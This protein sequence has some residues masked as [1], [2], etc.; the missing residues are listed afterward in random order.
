MTVRRWGDASRSTRDDPHP[1]SGPPAL[2]DA[3]MYALPA[4]GF[5]PFFAEQLPHADAV[6]ARVAAEHRGGYEVWSAVG[7]G[8]A[9]LAGRLVRQLEDDVAPGVGDWVTLE[10]PPAPDR[11]SIIDGVLARR[12]ALVRG[13][14]GRRSRAQTVAANVDLVFIVNGL[15]DDYNLHRIERYLARVWAGGAEPVIVLNKADLCDEVGA[16]VRETE[17][18]CPG[19]PVLVVSALRADGLDTLR[20]RLVEGL[21]AA[22][23]GSSGTGKSTLINALLGETRLPTHE[24]RTGDSRGR[25]T[26][27][28]RQLVLLPRGGLLIDTPGLRELQLLDEEGLAT[29]FADIEELAAHCRFRD[30][31]HRSEPGCAVRDAT[32]AGDL[33]PERLAHYFKL[34]A[35]ARSYE[36]RHD[37]RRRRAAERALGR[38]YAR[39]ATTLRRW[40]QGR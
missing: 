11:T 30:C 16:R 9:R 2:L 35:E 5:G 12:T 8:P 4:L 37:E 15:D 32:T 19:V 39:D 33:A 13:A 34:E 1:A 36:V 10:A 18:A 28:H 14:A 31:T 21:T 6:P 17:R 20:E 38:Q 25:H 27:T 26:T 40:K 22:F 23:V 24:V 3:P 7:E 29:V